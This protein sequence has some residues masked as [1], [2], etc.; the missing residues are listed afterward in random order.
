MKK[1][2]ALSLAV[3]TIMGLVCPVFA[4]SGSNE[5]CLQEVN[6]V[7]IP[8]DAE[9]SQEGEF[10]VYYNFYDPVNDMNYS[11]YNPETGE[12]FAISGPR[13]EVVGNG[14]RAVAKTV[15]EY[16][17]NSRFTVNGKQNGVTFTLPANKVYIEGNA[18]IIQESTGANVTGNYTNG[19]DYTIEVKEDVW[20]FPQSKTFS[21]VAGNPVSGSFQADGGTYYLIINPEDKLYDSDRI[22]GSGELYYYG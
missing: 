10:T 5:D 12:H 20:L 17:F 16:S 6:G 15:H 2:M 9:Y 4:T 22:K 14:V 11:F 1:I 13:Y 18:R 19:Y 3:L 7:Y 21:A 8:V